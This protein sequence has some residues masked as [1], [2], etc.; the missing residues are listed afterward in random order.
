MSS[1][2]HAPRLILSYPVALFC[3]SCF[4][5][6]LSAYSLSQNTIESAETSRLFHQPNQCHETWFRTAD[7]ATDNILL[8]YEIEYTICPLP[9]LAFARFDQ[10]FLSLRWQLACTVS[11]RLHWV[12][13]LGFCDDWLTKV[14][15]LELAMYW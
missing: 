10:S 3:W 11:R 9:A 8:V 15:A 6:F 4:G 12:T 13:S 1:Y 5:L 2:A 14:H 7:A